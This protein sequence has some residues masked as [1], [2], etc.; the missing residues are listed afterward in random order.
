MPNND[1]TVTLKDRRDGNSYTIVK[2]NGT[3]WVTQN[4]DLAGE[5]TLTSALSNV[6]SDYT[7]PA[8]SSTGFTNNAI[9][10]VYNSSNTTC[11]STSSCYGYY[12]FVAVSAGTG[13]TS[14]SSGNVTSDICPK[15]W[16]AE[17]TTLKNT[18]TT[19][20]TIT[21]SPWLGVYAGNRTNNN[22]NA[23]GSAGQY[24]SSTITGSE[25]A[26]VFYFY[27]NLT[28]VSDS[29]KRAGYSVRCIYNST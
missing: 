9:A 12:S 11:S 13:G 18:Y 26:S 28:N 2:I 24:W 16:R 10:Y 15:G 25:Y 19:G 1:D 8:S 7:L 21:A 4:L 14:V 29:D 20:A 5:T 17:Y 23:G 6:I 3:Y 22:F 27:S